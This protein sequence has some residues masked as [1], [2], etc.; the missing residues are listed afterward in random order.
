MEPFV[1]ADKNHPKKIA[2]ALRT[3]LRDA[4][5]TPPLSQCQELTARVL[6]HADWHALT[7]S[8][9]RASALDQVVPLEERNGR[10][11][12]A[13]GALLRFGLTLPVATSIHAALMPTAAVETLVLGPTARIA[14]S[15]LPPLRAV[16][17]DDPA[18]PS[19][20]WVASTREVARFDT[21]DDLSSDHVHWTNASASAAP[22]LRDGA[23]PKPQLK[24]DKYLPVSVLDILREWGCD[25]LAISPADSSIAAAV[26]LDR[27]VAIAHAMLTAASE[28]PAAMASAHRLSDALSS[29]LA[30]AA[31]PR[32][33]MA[34]RAEFVATGE[35][36]IK[37]GLWALL[38][39]PRLAHAIDMLRGSPIAGRVSMGATKRARWSDALE[40]LS[41]TEDSS[42]T[43]WDALPQSAREMLDSGS[44]SWALGVVAE[45]LWRSRASA[46]QP[47]FAAIRMQELDRTTMQRMADGLADRGW[48]VISF[49]LGWVRV[50]IHAEA[51]GELVAD[52]VE[53]G[54]LPMARPGGHDVDPAA[55]PERSSKELAEMTL[56]GGMHRLNRIDRAF[57]EEVAR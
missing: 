46:Q 45:A 28:D 7:S 17:F 26:A 38:R 37:G 24:H 12:V 42:T 21:L 32:S 10:R 47:D 15:T 5:L 56:R 39:R 22:W 43:A 13:I 44:A 53:L 33:P 11:A 23:T 31:S 35:R 54:L 52:G 18:S 8:S 19:S 51:M 50:S 20:G 6:G 40:P 48:S 16:L 57:C 25:P 29:L 41:F 27:I 1:H 49:G 9:A 3:L 36:G 34:H 55:W 14:P 30:G 4:G 2:K